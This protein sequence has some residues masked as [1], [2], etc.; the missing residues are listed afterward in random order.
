MTLSKAN[1]RAK[2][3]WA[4]LA[5]AVAAMTLVVVTAAL[6]VHDEDFQLDG[7]VIGST[8]TTKGG[9]TQTL[10]W[11]SLINANGTPKSSLPTGFDDA[12]FEKDF[13]NSGSTFITSD[14]ST[15]ATGSKDTLPIS[16]WQCNFDNNV[17]SKIDVMN[18]YAASYTDP[19][20]GDEIVY[21]ALERNTNTGDANVG[22]WFLQEDVGCETTGGAV[23]FSGGHQDGDLL[24]VSAFS[25]GGLVSTINVYRWNGGANGSL[26][27][28]PVATGVDCRSATLPPGDAACGAANTADITTPWL[29]SNFKDKVG[30]KLRVAE[31]FEGGVNLT[32][33]GLGGKCFNTFIGDTRSSTSLTATLFD[34][35][36]G[37][38]G[39]CASDIVTTPQDGSGTAIPAA[40]LSIGASARVD[41]RDHADI[42]VTGVDEFGGTVT[43]SLC[44]PNL[45]ATQN[46]Q[47]GG[48]QIGNPVAVTGDAGA[49][50]VNSPVATL[51][52]VG[53]YCWRAVY[54]GDTAAGVPGS[55]DPDDATNLSECFKVNP[56][57]PT[58][59]TQAGAD[60]VLGQS[61]TDTASLTGTAK[62]PGTD[63]I[64]PG[65]TINATAATQS[66]A[67]G[68]ITFNVRGPDTCLASGLTVTGSPVTVSGDNASYGPVSATPI[69]VG[70]YTFVAAYI[71]P[72]TNTLAAGPSS[73]PPAPTDG[74]EEVNVGGL[75]A[76]ST[77]QQWLPN[78]TAH[79]T[80]SP[81]T[82]LAGTVTFKLFNNGTC[83]GDSP[84]LTI[85]KNVVTDAETGGTAN[86]RTVKTNQ[87][88]YIVTTANDAVAWSWLVSYDDTAL[89]DSVADCETTTP[90]FTLN[91]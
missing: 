12:G 25:N 68:Q 59:T 75:T 23:T 57:Q 74:D 40:G 31:F 64:G 67:G 46:C 16:G 37:T 70:K 44:G 69:A 7:D 73:C 5:L 85:T 2:Q 21:F 52:S 91:H 88:G 19:Q 76:V 32:D 24:I 28:T 42:T 55:T 65:G 1:P 49:A 34:Y 80:S 60:V 17:N 62:Q 82:T 33:T 20:S 26:G 86:D 15:F 83:A 45:T 36:A 50:S 48:V 39:Q 63:G 13:Q 56:V 10:D 9:S 22:F 54:S 79:I 78:D 66:P 58:L 72:T 61:I 41:V 51:T 8:T 14:T 84:V 27:A 71:N 4:S 53:N 81:G 29:T 11:D 47:T 35:A 30:N 38:L 77:A 87:T 18:A 6:A 3:R 43:F 90:A 89:P